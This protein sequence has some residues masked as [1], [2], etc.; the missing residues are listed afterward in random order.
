MRDLVAIVLVLGSALALFT[1]AVARGDRGWFVPPP[2]ST[3]ETFVRHL[4]AR[5]YDRA[6]AEV[7]RDAHQRTDV[8]QLRAQAR[9]LEDS[10]G[11][12]NN[13]AGE[14]GTIDGER[15]TASVLVQG[16]RHVQRT[17]EIR[18]VREQ[19]LWRVDSWSW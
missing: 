6:L 14:P 8:A 4:A 17:V 9:A 13:A 19:G 10:V 2:E 18:L 11:G 15:A 12:I 5:R 16:R 1:T 3:S 7:S